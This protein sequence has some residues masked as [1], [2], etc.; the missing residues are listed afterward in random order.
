MSDRI[1]WDFIGQLEGAGKLD[2][3]VP[4]AGQSGV[5]IATGFDIGARNASDLALL[6]GAGSALYKAF[7]P[8]AGLKRVAAT[9]ALAKQNLKITTE[10]STQVNQ[11]VKA[12]VVSKLITRY[13]LAVASKR[14]GMP[15]L[16]GFAQL[17]REAQTVIASVEFQYGSIQSGAPNF[18]AQVTDQDWSAAYDNLKSFGDA[19]KT[20]RGKEAAY[21]LP[22]VGMDLTQAYPGIPHRLDLYCHSAPA[23]LPGVP[24]PLA[25]GSYRGPRHDDLFYCPSVGS[26]AKAASIGAA[27]KVLPQR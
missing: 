2:G 16:R 21:L 27:I 18:W 7:L 13:D 4:A 14:S 8:Y 17:P 20:R 9:A 1:D 10:Q 11:V 3:Y 26:R 23:L 19:Y 15:W 22:L 12:K 24:G 5:T 6:F 25:W